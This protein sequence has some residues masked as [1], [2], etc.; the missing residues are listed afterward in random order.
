MCC[1]AKN[2]STLPEARGRDQRP[3]TTSSLGNK[4]GFQG[5]GTKCK[6]TTQDMEEATVPEGMETQQAAGET[7]EELLGCDHARH[8]VGGRILLH[9]PFP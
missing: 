8:D 9:E 5:T 6:H 3:P 1:L 7:T 2:G 4:Q